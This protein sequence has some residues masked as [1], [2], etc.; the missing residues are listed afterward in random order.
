M[1]NE[2]YL[3]SK[4]SSQAKQQIV[5]QQMLSGYLRSTCLFARDV[6][7]VWVALFCWFMF[8]AP[9]SNVS[10][11]IWGHFITPPNCSHANNRSGNHVWSCFHNLSCLS[12]L[13]QMPTVYYHK[14]ITALSNMGKSF[15]DSLAFWGSW[16]NITLNC[17]L[18]ANFFC[19][20]LQ[21]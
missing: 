4:I 8:R 15:E 11:R 14:I 20:L 17:F 18:W 2:A 21:V 19:C 13:D 12:V 6:L 7:T 1:S 16:L 5:L 9:A 3:M 10:Q